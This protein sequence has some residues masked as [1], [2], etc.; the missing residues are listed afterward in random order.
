M[1]FSHDI[2]I[3]WDAPVC[4]SFSKQTNYD[5]LFK[6]VCKDYL[7]AV[8]AS[9]TMQTANAWGLGGSIMSMKWLKKIHVLLF[10]SKSGLKLDSQ[11]LAGLQSATAWKWRAE[12]TVELVSLLVLSWF[13]ILE[14]Q[15][16][17]AFSSGGFNT[18]IS[19]HSHLKTEHGEHSMLW[20]YDLCTVHYELKRLS[21]TLYKRCKAAWSYIKVSF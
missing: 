18:R 17:S 14:R 3:Y 6:T 2:L 13:C 11:F 7:W 10:T 21:S 12:N 4:M 19:I 9:T 8:A 5:I 1:K 16:K 15:S 20:V